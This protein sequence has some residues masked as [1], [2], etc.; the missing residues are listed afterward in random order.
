MCT[1]PC[2]RAHA[3]ARAFCGR[4]RT[5][6]RVH[7]CGVRKAT[8]LLERAR[9]TLK[10]LRAAY[11]RTGP[12]AVSATTESTTSMMLPAAGATGGG[13]GMSAASSAAAAEGQRAPTEMS[14]T[15]VVPSLTDVRCPSAQASAVSRT[16]P[17]DGL[18]GWHAP[19]WTSGVWVT[20]RF[21]W[22]GGGWLLDRS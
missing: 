10:P 19:T 14:T 9:E 5:C 15:V 2:F 13:G 4:V 22:A 17:P 11:A 8:L 18:V 1:C 7:V 21:V 12:A 3:R 16:W 6:T 20:G